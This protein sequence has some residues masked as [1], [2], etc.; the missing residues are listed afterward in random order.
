LTAVFVGRLHEAAA[1]KMRTLDLLIRRHRNSP[2]RS[3]S[4]PASHRPAEQCA[5]GGSY[6][7]RHRESQRWM[8][9]EPLRCL[10]QEFFGCITA[11]L[12]STFH[13]AHGIFD[14]FGNRTG[15]A[16]GLTS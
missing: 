3:F 13:Y 9:L 15:C 14:R 12:R 4:L 8:P 2:F 1:W 11:L 16:R 5:C 7:E 6:C 10:M